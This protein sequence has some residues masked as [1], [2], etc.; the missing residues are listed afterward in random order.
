MQLTRGC[1]YAIR[2][3]TY[4]AMHEEEHPILLADIAKGIGAP[5][6]YLS[7]IFQILNR[8]DLVRSHRGAKRGYSLSQ[9]P[10]EINLRQIVEGIEGPISVSS[11]TMD[12]GWCELDDGCSLFCI[13]DD[14]QK[15][16]TGK[17]EATTLATLSGACFL[18]ESKEAKEA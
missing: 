6:N 10:A 4:L 7:N 14:I 16:I 11:C 13:W 3:L 8:L 12:A 2:A 5:P 18:D 15:T 1:E 9:A 17:L